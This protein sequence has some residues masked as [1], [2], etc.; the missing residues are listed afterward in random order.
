MTLD[1]LAAD[2]GSSR[3]HLIRL[4]KGD[5]R[6]RLEMLTHIADA[7]GKPV[8]YFL[9]VEADENPFQEDDRAA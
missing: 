1:G 3:H 5:H 7:T 4:E 2:V 6:P 9:D 8:D